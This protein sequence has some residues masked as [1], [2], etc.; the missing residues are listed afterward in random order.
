MVAAIE[1]NDRAVLCHLG[2]KPDAT[3]AED[4]A[5]SVKGN[6]WTKNDWLDV[7]ALRLDVAANTR[8]ER[9]CL[10]LER[11]LAAT[12][13]DRAIERVIRQQELED[14]TLGLLH[15]RASGAHLHAISDG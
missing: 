13:A 5:L 12:V 9:E 2:A 4:A 8:T 3:P 10:I 7:V 14:A 1:K 6:G 11:A 15:D